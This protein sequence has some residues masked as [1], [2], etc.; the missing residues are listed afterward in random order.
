MDDWESVEFNY[1]TNRWKN[2]NEG[3]KRDKKS[4]D[5][6]PNFRVFNCPSCK[7]E[8]TAQKSTIPVKCPKCSKTYCF[9]CNVSYYVRIFDKNCKIDYKILLSFMYRTFTRRGSCVKAKTK[10]KLLR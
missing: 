2:I 3:W 6:K 4:R 9:N 7:V 10:L 1:G 5:D 8:I